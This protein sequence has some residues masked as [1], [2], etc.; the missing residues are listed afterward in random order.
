MVINQINQID[1]EISESQNIRFNQVVQTVK[2][3][4][5]LTQNYVLS[6]ILVDDVQIHEINKQYRQIDS[7]TDVIS[8]A[9]LEGEQFVHEQ[10]EVELGDVFISIETMK[11]QANEYGH[12]EEREFTFLFTHGLLHLLGYDHIEEKDEKIMFSLQNEILDEIIKK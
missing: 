2:Q 12:S 6:L 7:P 3:K 11:R 5:D 1:Y 8:F 4:L 10:E 9:S